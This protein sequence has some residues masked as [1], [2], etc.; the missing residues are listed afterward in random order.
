MLFKCYECSLNVVGVMHGVFFQVPPLIPL[1]SFVGF[2]WLVLP[3]TLLCKLEICW[4]LELF[5]FY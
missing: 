2:L 1:F 4:K 5:G 3:L